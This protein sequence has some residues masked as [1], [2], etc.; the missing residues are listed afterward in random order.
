MPLF[1]MSLSRSSSGG[2]NGQRKTTG[3][4]AGAAGSANGGG[5]LPELS[6]GKTT[7]REP[8]HQAEAT[9]ATGLSADD[10]VILG[11]CMHLW[12]V[13]VFDPLVEFGA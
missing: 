5:S 10:G 8:P 11:V 3:A 13:C 7:G 4:G 2:S 1:P 12:G 9:S 6:P